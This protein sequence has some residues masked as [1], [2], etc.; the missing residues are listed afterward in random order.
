MNVGR[1]EAANLGTCLKIVN[2][3]SLVERPQMKIAFGFSAKG[4]DRVEEL[5][6]EWSRLH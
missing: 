5:A 3:L 1:R 2:K 4:S 6:V